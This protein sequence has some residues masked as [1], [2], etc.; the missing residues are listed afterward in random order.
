MGFN[1]EKYQKLLPYQQLLFLKQEHFRL[2]RKQQNID[3][4]FHDASIKLDEVYTA[5]EV[6]KKVDDLNILL[7]QSVGLLAEI[8]YL[9]DQ[10]EILIRELSN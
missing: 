1:L 10:L 5:D 8:Q 6:K 9:H 7:S 2:H 3:R 4:E